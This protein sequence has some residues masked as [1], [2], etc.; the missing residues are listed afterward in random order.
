MQP[1][2]IKKTWPK[3]Y[4]PKPDALR[5]YHRWAW[6]NEWK[7]VYLASLAGASQNRIAQMFGGQVTGAKTWPKVIAVLPI[8]GIELLRQCPCWNEYAEA[9]WQARL[10]NTGDVP[11]S[12][13]HS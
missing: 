12:A 13:E 4:R 8:E 6:E 11:T 1:A 3:R 7:Q 2:T 5:R 9:A 10:G